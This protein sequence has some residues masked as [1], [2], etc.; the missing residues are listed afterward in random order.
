M[1][2]I[3]FERQGLNMLF[4]IVFSDQPLLLFLFDQH[5]GHTSFGM[6]VFNLS[7]AIMG[8]GILGLSFAMANTGI[9]LFT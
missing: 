1:S 6:S 5:P 4:M 7:N 8:S 9:V 3:L 2:T